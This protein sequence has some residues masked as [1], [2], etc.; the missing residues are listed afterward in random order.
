MRFLQ[1]VCSNVCEPYV[2]A[3]WSLLHAPKKGIVKE[4]GGKFGA[5]L[6]AVRDD[7]DVKE[8]PIEWDMAWFRNAAAHEDSRYLPSSGELELWDDR[9]PANRF[10]PIAGEVERVEKRLSE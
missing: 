10:W 1:S 8:V 3:G 5:V 2:R 9:R 4:H 6:N 7:F